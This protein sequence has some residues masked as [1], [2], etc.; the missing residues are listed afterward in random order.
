MIIKP[1]MEYYQ[2]CY[3]YCNIC[4]S[5]VRQ[6]NKRK[7]SRGSAR[8][9]QGWNRWAQSFITLSCVIILSY[10]HIVKSSWLTLSWTDIFLNS[11]PFFF[12]FKCCL[13]A[14]FALHHMHKLVFFGQTC[15]GQSGKLIFIN[16]INLL[17]SII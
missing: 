11:C 3:H 12:N 16:H 1:T 8:L 6:S 5:S 10:H 15:P 2:I 13:M 7:F 9:G 17:Y 14:I 4:R